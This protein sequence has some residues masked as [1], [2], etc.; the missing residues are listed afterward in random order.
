MVIL[1]TVKLG[2]EEAINDLKEEQMRAGSDNVKPDSG[3]T[4]SLRMCQQFQRTK[5]SFGK[6]IR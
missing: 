4:P 5:Q 1:Q 2:N 3:R 6:Q